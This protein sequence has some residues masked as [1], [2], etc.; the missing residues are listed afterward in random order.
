MSK[1]K[2]EQLRC[3]SDVLVE[4]I[5]GHLQRH[6]SGELG[7]ERLV[8]ELVFLSEH[9]HAEIILKIG[10][11]PWPLRFNDAGLNCTP[12]VRL[13]VENDEGRKGY[14]LTGAE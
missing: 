4:S 11:P 13:I 6:A 7:W 14:V 8:Q 5:F 2:K 3:E 10:P 9:H 12:K 1:N